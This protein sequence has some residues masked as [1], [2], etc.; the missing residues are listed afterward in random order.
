MHAGQESRNLIWFSAGGC[1]P[2]DCMAGFPGS[3]WRVSDIASMDAAWQ[4]L[5][6]HPEACFAALFDIRG[7]IES[8]QLEHMMPLL[9]EPRI[10]WVAGIDS[11]QLESAQLRQLIHGC[12]HDFVTLPCDPALLEVV[13]GH[14]LGMAELSPGRR[15]A[16]L[17]EVDTDG[18]IG[19]SQPMRAM[20]RMLRKAAM[21]DAPVYIAGE[22]GTG[23]ELAAQAIHRR[24]SRHDRPFIAI[25]CGAIPGSLVQS[26]LF[27]YERGAFT[28]AIQRKL[29]RIEL[30]H[31]GTL[32]LDEIGDL[33]LDSQ[34]ALL[35]FLQEGS[36]ERLGGRD[37][38]RVDARIISATHVDL[39]E[40]VL[41][42]RFRCDLLHRLQ[43]IELRQPPLR[44]RGD[45]IQLLAEH[46][47]RHYAG[48][49]RLR[50]RGFAGCA[51]RALH[52]YAWPGNVRELINRVRQ[53]VV[54]AESPYITARDLH[55]DDA[56]GLAQLTLEDARSKGEREAIAQAL[57]RNAYHLGATARDL[58]IS[59]VTLYRLMN[60]HQLRAGD[61]L[62][63]VMA[64]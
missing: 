13:L 3:G 18:M 19:R 9:L 2:A 50:I 15:L 55:L 30:A 10:G 12:C 27:G 38:I 31:T 37:P 23:K 59:R 1:G 7:G 62:G 54:M 43:V 64:G 40:A 41:E 45:D 47:L 20:F 14:A 48:E 44:E 39:A 52:R 61:G 42:G 49:S 28:G 34:A 5:R 36:I 4:V 46:A 17:A 63:T 32:F 35:R 58:D 21:T 29:G 6:Q 24:S 8:G 60:R 26:E 53:A 56:A 33:P 51:K 16:P 57:R 25:N 22:T 11:S